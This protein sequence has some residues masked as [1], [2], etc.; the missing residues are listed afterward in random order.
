MTWELK[1]WVA[2]R[3]GSWKGGELEWSIRG[4]DLEGRRQE[5][6]LMGG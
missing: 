6:N 4:G 3:D 1:G 5:L 2:G